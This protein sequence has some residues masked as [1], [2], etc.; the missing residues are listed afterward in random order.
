MSTEAGAEKRHLRRFATLTQT[1]RGWKENERDTETD[2]DRERMKD[3]EDED[4]KP[5]MVT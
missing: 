4:L 5:E 2:R 1:E 3:E